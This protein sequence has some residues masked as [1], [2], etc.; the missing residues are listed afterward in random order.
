MIFIKTMVEKELY[1][2]T[3]HCLVNALEA[4][5]I[6]TK[7]HSIRVGDMAFELSKELNLSERECEIIHISGHLHDIGKIG[8]PETI[9]NK[10][11]KL[12][13]LEWKEMK[14]HPEIGYKI[15]GESKRLEDIRNIVLTHHERWDGMGYPRA[16]SGLDIP[17][18][19]RIIAICDSID[20]MTSNRHYRNAFGWDYCWNE[21]I[22]NRG[23]QF[24]PYIVDKLKRLFFIWKDRYS[25]NNILDFMKP[26]S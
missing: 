14:R 5:D 2:D 3:V 9:L 23:M 1:H 20:A 17:I 6:Y 13:N 15:L 25:G 26:V 22:K 18:G 24:D 7:G 12:T 11:G 4:K 19:G 21:I 16:L 8:I 10:K